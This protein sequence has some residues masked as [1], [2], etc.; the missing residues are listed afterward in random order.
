MDVYLGAGSNI[1]PELNIIRALKLTAG[2]GISITALSTHYRTAAIGHG[3][4]PS[5]INGVWKIASPETSQS[6]LDSILK[7]IEADC[8]RVRTSDKWADRTIDLDIL[9]M[10]DYI[11]SDV[12]C[13]DFIYLPLLELD[14]KLKTPSGERLSSLVDTGLTENM[15]ALPGFTAELRRIINE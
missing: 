13:R 15:Q 4:N 14:K 1:E 6:R 7:E 3:N 5:Y 8:G 11:S 10:K 2:R 9:L 12:L